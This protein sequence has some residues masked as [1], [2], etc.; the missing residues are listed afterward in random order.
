MI[1]AKGKQLN[2]TE[3]I[4]RS[5]SREDCKNTIPAGSRAQYCSDS[6]CRRIRSKATLDKFLDDKKKKYGKY[7]PPSKK[8]NPNL[9]IQSFRIN[10]EW[11]KTGITIHCCAKNSKCRCSESFVVRYRFPD[12]E[13]NLPNIFPRFCSEHRNEYKRKRFEEQ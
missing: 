4:E 12:I 7:I 2:D 6:E 8:I 5:C 1:T 3:K 9:N 13:N 10:K 11:L